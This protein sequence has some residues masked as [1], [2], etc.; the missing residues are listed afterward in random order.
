MFKGV[1]FGV[2]GACCPIWGMFCGCDVAVYRL[3]ATAATVAMEPPL[4]ELTGRVVNEWLDSGTEE[5]K[6][7]VP[8]TIVI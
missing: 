8:P 3:L 1:E 4:I 2:F 6:P 7:E 5:T